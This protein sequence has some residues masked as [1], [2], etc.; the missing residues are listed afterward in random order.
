LALVLATDSHGLAIFQKNRPATLTYPPIVH[1]DQDAGV[2]VDRKFK[3]YRE[4]PKPKDSPA[5]L[6]SS[7]CSSALIPMRIARS[8]TECVGAYRDDS[9]QCTDER[10]N[11]LRLICFANIASRK[12]I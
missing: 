4:K 2:D 10:V 5:L 8:I 9:A 3:T 12:I 11:T 6:K 7:S 1:G